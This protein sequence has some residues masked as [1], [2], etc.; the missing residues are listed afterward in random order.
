MISTFPSKA[1][2][3]LDNPI[4]SERKRHKSN[5][6]HHQP[7]KSQQQQ[8]RHPHF[9]ESTTNQKD[10]PMHE[11]QQQ[12]QQNNFNSNTTSHSPTHGTFTPIT[13]THS[14]EFLLNHESKF[15]I[16]MI[17]EDRF[18]EK[19]NQMEHN[20]YQGEEMIE[21]PCGHMHG[22]GQGYDHDIHAVGLADVPLL[23]GPD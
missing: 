10:H 22:P 14:H 4:D 15:D 2:H 11:Q 21:C 6:Y 17:T 9:D 3:Q 8:Q 19:S 13:Q 1:N 5:M 12:Q 18:I 23:R 16:E 20:Q 7:S